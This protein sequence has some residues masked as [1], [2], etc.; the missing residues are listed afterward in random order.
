MNV[1]NTV[2]FDF[3]GILGRNPK[4]ELVNSHHSTFGYSHLKPLQIF[5]GKSLIYALINKPGKLRKC[6]YDN[7]NADFKWTSYN[8]SALERILD[9]NTQRDVFKKEGLLFNPQ[10]P[11]IRLDIQQKSI[12]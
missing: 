6:L 12:L 1:L 8:K 3:E 9:E 10:N 2:T 7:L 5:G 4:Q 11:N